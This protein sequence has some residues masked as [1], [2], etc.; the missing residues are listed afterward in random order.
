MWTYIC[1]LVTLNTVINYPLW[2]IRS[3]STFFIS[4]SSSRECTI[5]YTIECTYW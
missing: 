5:F 2:Y 3:N 4:S 1:T